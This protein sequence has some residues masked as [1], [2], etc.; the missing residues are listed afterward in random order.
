MQTGLPFYALLV[1]LLMVSRIP[2]PHIIN[3]VL[4]GQRGFGHV[5]ALVF[6]TVAIM[7]VHGYSVPIIGCTLVLYAPLKYAWQRIFDR[8]TQDP[9]F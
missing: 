4:R 7:S 8:V 1:A 2:Y 9:I 3:Q 6:F 5:V